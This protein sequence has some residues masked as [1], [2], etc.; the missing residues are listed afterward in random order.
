MIAIALLRHGRTAWN[1]MGRIQGHADIPLSERGRSELAALSLPPD[2]IGTRWFA[3]PLAR[4]LETARCLEV[5][6][7]EPAPALIEMDWGRWSG[8]TL[9][10]LRAA[11]PDGMAENEARGLDFR[12]LGGETPR[13]AGA[14]VM[15]WLAS[16]EGAVAHCAAVTHKGII[17]VLIAQAMHWDMTGPPPVKVN[18]TALHRFTFHNGTLRA[19]RLNEPLPRRS[20]PSGDGAHGA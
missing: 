8:A 9:A 20:D 16:L 6:A 17:L 14:R 12:P 2:L 18:W 10:A 15:D 19:E 13:E 3:S 7:P 1:E 11:D 4:A 5:A